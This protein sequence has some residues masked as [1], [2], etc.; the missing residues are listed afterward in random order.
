M[1][2]PRGRDGTDWGVGL[3][4]DQGTMIHRFRSYEHYEGN[5]VVSYHSA[6]IKQKRVNLPGAV[7]I[8]YL[9]SQAFSK[10][11]MG[12]K[13]TPREDQLY[14]IADEY[15]ENGIY[16][17]PNQKDW[18]AGYN[19]IT[20]VFQ[21]DP[22]HIHPLTGEKGAP[23]CYVFANCPHFI[24]EVDSY[25]W[26]KVRTGSAFKEE[27]QDDD[28]HHMDGLNGFLTSRPGGRPTVVG[29][30]ELR[31]D[32]PSWLADLERESMGSVSHMAL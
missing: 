32:N 7:S 12:Q 28:D 6:I 25:R 21:S 22:N 16:V 29:G 13:G 3:Y 1:R 2:E 20:E 31:K 10:T 26:K 9:D 4:G 23:H 14:S 27:P 18:D 15:V 11:L 17:V 5:K 24:G 19:R 30:I 8:T